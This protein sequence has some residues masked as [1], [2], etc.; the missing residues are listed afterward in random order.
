MNCP[1]C[2]FSTDEPQAMYAHV[3]SAARTGH[4][5]PGQHQYGVPRSIAK[6]LGFNYAGGF[7]N[8]SGHF[9]MG[10]LEVEIK[11]KS[12]TITGCGYGGRAIRTGT[13]FHR[14]LVTCP[15]CRRKIPAGRMHQ[16]GHGEHAYHGEKAR[17]AARAARALLRSME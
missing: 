7:P 12:D 8:V 6:A 11:P 5:R 17:R 1:L 2:T 4:N 13:G 9:D 3:V 15:T 14:I 16:H 10:G